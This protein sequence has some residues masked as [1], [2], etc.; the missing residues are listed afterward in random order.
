[1]GIRPPH[2]KEV[3]EV[4][5]RRY[6]EH[7]LPAAL[8]DRHTLP[9]LRRAVDDALIRQLA[10]RVDIFHPGPGMDLEP[11][12]AKPRPDFDF[13]V[14]RAQPAAIEDLLR[15]ATL[16]GARRV[17]VGEVAVLPDARAKLDASP[18]EEAEAEREVPAIPDGTVLRR[19][20]RLYAQVRR[21]IALELL[22]RLLAEV[23]D[24]EGHAATHLPGVG[25]ARRWL[26]RRRRRRVG[27]VERGTALKQR[28]E[29]GTNRQCER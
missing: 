17:F 11:L 25:G 24:G 3:R 22:A 13:D 9:R 21:E 28:H 10:M 23:P 29:H 16:T 19:T 4:G 6:A 26:R 2:A 1:M 5:G 20:R 14:G 15:L 27:R 12:R 7:G 8:V 18:L